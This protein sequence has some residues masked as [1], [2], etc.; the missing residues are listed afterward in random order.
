MYTSVLY[1]SSAFPCDGG[2]GLKYCPVP[3]SP[4]DFVFDSINESNIEFFLNKQYG[5]DAWSY[6]LLPISFRAPELSE[7][8][9]RIPVEVR[10][11]DPTLV[12]RYRSIEVF[13]YRKVK[14]WNTEKSHTPR[15][16]PDVFMISR[17]AE[18]KLSEQIVPYISMRIRNQDSSELRMIAV[19]TPIDRSKRIE[20]VKQEKTIKIMRCYF[21]MDVYV[22]GQWP[23]GLT[24]ECR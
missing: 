8:S 20:V 23:N 4:S 3:L 7:N 6:T 18:Y 5:R 12:G 10:A 11:D 21:D 22:D 9:T 17:V 14:V 13:V 16:A 1:S 15:Y 2:G 19:F 24:M